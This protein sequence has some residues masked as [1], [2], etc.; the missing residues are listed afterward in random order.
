MQRR[1]LLVVVLLL[2]IVSAAGGFY[3]Q[4]LISGD[5]RLTAVGSD[6]PGQEDAED[7]N[8]I[9][10]RPRPPF[11]LPDLSGRERH[12]S[13]WDGQVVVVNFWATWCSPC[14]KE[15]PEFIEL[16]SRYGEEGLQF[17]GIALQKPSE[18]VDFAAEY[19]M[20][21]PVLAGEMPVVRLAETYGNDIGALPYTVVVNRDG[22]IVFT[23]QGPVTGPEMESIIG[24]L[25]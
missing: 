12:I 18:V 13:E 3:L 5:G 23:R 8:A 22:D 16:Q 7:V 11:S 15:V 4:R 20:N 25:L 19:G 17:I 24:P 14:L 21:Y 10:G 1:S 9:I 6:S 2:V